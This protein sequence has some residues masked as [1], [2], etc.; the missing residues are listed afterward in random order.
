MQIVSPKQCLLSAATVLLLLAGSA[1]AKQADALSECVDLAQGNQ[2]VRSGGGNHFLLKDGDSHYKVSLSRNC[3]SLP[4]A[5]KIAIKTGEQV[6][7]LCPTGTV[8]V[9]NRDSCSVGEV[10]PVDAEEFARQQRRRR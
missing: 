2:I 6:N 5:S 9:T 10:T 1:H 4:T 8:V 7:R 3:G